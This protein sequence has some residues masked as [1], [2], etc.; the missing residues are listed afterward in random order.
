[1]V[2]RCLIQCRRG[3]RGYGL[4][5]TGYRGVWEFLEASPLSYSAR[6]LNLP[7][8]CDLSPVTRNLGPPTNHRVIT[9]VLYDAT[10]VQEAKN[11]PGAPGSQPG[12]YSDRLLAGNVL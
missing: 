9:T 5:V 3:G 4:Q 8:P 1:M 11:R 6:Q 12:E 10:L 2:I 7:A